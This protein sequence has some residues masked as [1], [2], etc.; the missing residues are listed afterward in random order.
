MLT[1]GVI[2]A[3]GAGLITAKTLLD[4]GFNVTD[5]TR[6]RSP[7][8]IWAEE[9]VYPGLALNKYVTSSSIGLFVALVILSGE[10]LPI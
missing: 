5:L 3:G 1:V 6:D 2:G 8:G 7:G 9:R 10:L 4:D